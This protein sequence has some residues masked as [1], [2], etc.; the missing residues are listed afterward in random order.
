MEKKL[1]PMMQQY[2][3]MKKENQ[4]YI[5][6][7]RLGDF[8]EMF[9]DDAKTVSKELDIVLTGRDCGLEERAPMCGVPY[10]SVDSYIARLI[11]KGYKI[12]VCEQIK[13]EGTNEVIGREIVRKITPGTVTEP[14]MLSEEK[15]NYISAVFVLGKE[16]CLCFIDISTGDILLC[17]PYKRNSENVLNELVRYNP[18]ELFLNPE[19]EKLDTVKDYLRFNPLCI[20]TAAT[21]NQDSKALIEKH[22]LKTLRE[23]SIEDGSSMCLTF[24]SLLKYLYDT[25]LCDLSHI[26]QFKLQQEKKNLEIDAFAWRNLEIVETMRYREKK[27]SLLGILDKTKTP[28]GARLLRKFLEKP[29]NSLLEIMN[30]QSVVRDFFEKTRERE[31]IRSLLCKFGDTERLLTKVVYKTIS[32]REAKALAVSFSVLPDIKRILSDKQFSANYTKE[33]CNR[34]DDLSDICKYLDE[35]LLEDSETQKLAV[36]QKEGSIIKDGYDADVDEYRAL[37]R[38]AKEILAEI[39]TKE[40]ERT[41]IKNLKIKYNKVFGYSI[42]ITNA[43]KNVSLPDDYI[44]KQ[45][46]ANGERFITEEL[47][48]TEY[49]LEN[50]TEL[51]NQREFE[52]FSQLISNL[53]KNISRIRRTTNIVAELDVLVNFAE[54]AVKNN[55]VCPVMTEKTDL[56]IKN[57]RHPV[58]E[59]NLDFGMYVPNDTFLNT[60]SDRMAIITGPNMAGKST[61]MRAVALI[62]IM[63]HIGSFVPASAAEIGIIDKVFTRVGASDDLAAG[64]STFMVEMSE[65]AYILKNASKKSLIIFD[66]IGRGTSTFDGMS[67]ARAVLEY[68]SEKICAKSMFATHYHELIALEKTVEGV[69]NYSIAAKKRDKEIIFLRKIVKGGTDDS[70]GIDVARLA[71]V[72]EAVIDRAEEVLSYLE[73]QRPAENIRSAPEPEQDQV[74]LGSVLSDDIIEI[75]KNTDPTV[76]T[77]IEA[78]NTLYDLSKKAKEL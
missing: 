32:P 11:A 50:A 63:A 43:N 72:P 48:E 24:G 75:L 33:L 1:S 53:E 60:S 42:E 71:G 17:E 36:S 45:T 35:M 40:R 70:Y 18:N 7:Y 57:G 3:E 38:S 30:R 44:R 78:M 27:G 77:P 55:Y 68:V 52:L 31:E 65:V 49:K 8:Y 66:E 54:I 46:L 37:R 41:G 39:E 56:I 51:Q 76:L 4:D 74:L 6:M 59:K 10:H 58:V 26:R 21:V 73:S 13:K 16:V 62:V 67:I 61:Y 19:A 14:G 22:M 23:L 12:S 5:L 47:K 28:P 15:N 2:I 9:F 20:V 29:S 34:I 69:K 64:Q 25:Q